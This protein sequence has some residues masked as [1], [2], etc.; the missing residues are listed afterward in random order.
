MIMANSMAVQNAKYKFN[1]YCGEISGAFAD[2]GTF[3]PL[4]L[5]LIALNQFSPQGIFL[6]FGIFAIA[7][8]LF[9]KRPIPV[10]PMKVITALVISQGL[11]PAMLQASGMLMGVI[12]IVLALSGAIS[13]MSKQL[14]P[15]VSI[16]IQLAIG[17]QLMLMG[18]NMM[19]ES[20][21]IGFGTFIL[22][23]LSRFLPMQYLAMPLVIGLGMLWQFSLNENV[24]LFDN[25]QPWQLGWPTIDEWSQA[26]VLLVLPQLALT[27]TNAVIATSAM[28]TEK[29]PEDKQKLTPKHLALSS[30]IANFCLAP[31]GATSMCHGA[32]GL[33]VQYHFGARRMWAPLIFGITCLLIA[34]CWGNDVAWLL[35]LIPMAILGS[36]L[37]IAG[38]QLAYNKN[39]LHAKPYCIAVILFT[40]LFCLLVNTAVG[41][42]VGVLMELGRRYIAPCFK[43]N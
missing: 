9:Y 10:Q 13:W 5:G 21:V 30:G 26:A 28:A 22:L 2:L 14:S 34:I 1:Q 29:F 43:H 11:S 20:W 31:F 37:S 27:L 39:I 36:L 42:L 8:A 17:I 4:V 40:A 12:L 38:Y 18:F 35:G 24:V 25:Y 19:S 32:G 23:F 7:T 15:A 3:L 6:G 33:A 41:L 16:G